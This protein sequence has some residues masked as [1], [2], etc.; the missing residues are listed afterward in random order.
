MLCRRDPGAGNLITFAQFLL[1][2]H[3]K[4]SLSQLSTSHNK[5]LTPLPPTSLP[6]FQHNSLTHSACLSICSP[7]SHWRWPFGFTPRIVPLSVY[8]KI[9]AIFFFTSLLNNKALDYSISIPVHTVFRSSGLCATLLLGRFGYHLRY[10]RHQVLACLL[11]TVGI[12][13]VTVMDGGKG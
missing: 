9:T 7:F 3:Q 10:P 2:L 8:A 5:T 6:S 4:V 12:L 11:V 13:A 1:I